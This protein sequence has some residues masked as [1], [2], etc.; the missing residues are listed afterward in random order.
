MMAARMI[1]NRLVVAGCRRHIRL[2]L[3]AHSEGIGTIAEGIIALSEDGWI[4]GA[5]RKLDH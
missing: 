4:V 1:E 2:H 5:N 3:H